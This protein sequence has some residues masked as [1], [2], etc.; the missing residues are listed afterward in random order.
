MFQTIMLIPV[1]F[2]ERCVWNIV[3][4]DSCSITKA[5]LIFAEL[6]DAQISRQWYIQIQFLPRSVHSGSPIGNITDL[7]FGKLCL[8]VLT[9]IHNTQKPNVLEV[10]KSNT[11][12]RNR[13]PAT[14]T[15]LSSEAVP[16]THMYELEMDGHFQLYASAAI[17]SEK[18]FVV[19]F[20]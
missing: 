5:S 12:T 15:E 2:A 17:T 10:H 6:S 4:A 19:S 9:I 14:A 20:L 3:I 13:P 18:Q 7:C 1:H 8:F 11:D 16:R